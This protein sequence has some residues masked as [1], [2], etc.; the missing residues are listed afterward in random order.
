MRPRLKGLA[1]V[2]VPGVLRDVAVLEK[3]LVDVPVLFLARQKITAFQEQ[4]AFARRCQPVRQRA[5][6]GAGANDDHIIVLV[7]HMS[8]LR[9]FATLL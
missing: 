8:L 1:L 9:L 7:H 5:A 2:V 4:N 6:A 3:D